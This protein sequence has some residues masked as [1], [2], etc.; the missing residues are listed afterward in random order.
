M[1]DNAMQ[2]GNGVNKEPLVFDKQTDEE[3]TK[4]QTVLFRLETRER[5][6]S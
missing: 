5:G 4:R 3:M 1:S 2:A 6:K